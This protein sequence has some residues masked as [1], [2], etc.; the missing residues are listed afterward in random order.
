MNADG[1]VE[2]LLYVAEKDEGV[3]E[4]GI[5]PVGLE[6]FHEAFPSISAPARDG[7]EKVEL[8]AERF[9][10]NLGSDPGYRYRACSFIDRIREE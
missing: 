2:N 5:A 10:S 7:A 8:L 1:V 6:G 4:T 9:P 3:E